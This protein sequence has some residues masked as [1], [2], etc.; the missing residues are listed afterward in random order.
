MNKNKIQLI[1]VVSKLVIQ[2]GNLVVV[3]LINL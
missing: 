3:W 2:P 1:V